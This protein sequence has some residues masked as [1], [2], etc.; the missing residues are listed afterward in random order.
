[1]QQGGELTVITKTYDLI[2]WA[3]PRTSRFPRQ[4]R[5]V[6]GERI[7][8]RLHDLLGTLIQAR[9]TRQRPPLL[10]QANRTLEVL[11]FHMRLAKDLHNSD[12][13]TWPVGE[14]LPNDLE[15]PATQDNAWTWC[16]ESAWGYPP[17][18]RACP[19]SG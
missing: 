11:R 7:E 4:L 15:L 3:C 2:R 17:G 18:T 19:R 14:K 8:R 1:M 9:Y 10:E 6:L 16:Q 13:R 5:F 12:E